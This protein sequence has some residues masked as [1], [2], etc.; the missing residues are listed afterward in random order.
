MSDKPLYAMKLHDVITVHH[1]STWI[2]RVPGGW[3][4]SF[5]RLDC[6]Q[7]NSVFVPYNSEFRET[8]DG[9]DRSCVPQ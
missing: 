3:I 4:Y 7:M 2:T 5:H 8:D 6:G 9:V 1:G